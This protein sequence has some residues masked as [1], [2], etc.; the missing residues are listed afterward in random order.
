M[1]NGWLSCAAMPII[2]V[3]TSEIER[4]VGEWLVLKCC[5][6]TAVG[7][8][9]VPLKSSVYIGNGWFSLSLRAL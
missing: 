3:L 4:V 9:R 8:E 5:D 1:G 7:V 2:C 6:S